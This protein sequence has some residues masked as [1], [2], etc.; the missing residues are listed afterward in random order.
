MVTIIRRRTKPHV[1]PRAVNAPLYIGVWPWLLGALLLA[2]APQ[3]VRLPLWLSAVW[4]VVPL[5]RGWLA[6]RGEPLPSRW[7]L[8]PLT[9]ALIGGVVLHYGTVFGRDAGVALLAAMTAMKLLETRS[10]RD[11]QVMVLL[12]YFLLMANLLF[13]Q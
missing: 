9:L 2:M 7:L 11:A 6:Y 12:G 13:S 8:L 4:I 3:M 1:A 10:V 5:W